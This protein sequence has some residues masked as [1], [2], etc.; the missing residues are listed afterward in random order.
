M[1]LTPEL[2]K[3]RQR[4]LLESAAQRR[5]VQRVRVHD[6]MLRRAERADRQLVDTWHRAAE[7]RAK[8]AELESANW[9]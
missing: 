1:Q 7:L 3:D 8:L 2:V 9:H 5:E 6:R 4:T